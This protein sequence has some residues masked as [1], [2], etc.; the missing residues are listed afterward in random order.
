MTDLLLIGLGS[1]GLRHFVASRKLGYKVVGVDPKHPE[2]LH[3]DLRDIELHTGLAGLRGRSFEY[4][5]IANWGPDHISTLREVHELNLSSKF[6]VEKPLSGS[7][8]DLRE[9]QILTM[10]GDVEFT[11]SFP[12][13]YSDFQHSVEEATNGSPTSIS[14]WGGA[15]CI[16]TNGSHWLDLAIG[17]FGFPV[18]VMAN[19]DSQP[20]NP[21]SAE[22]DFVEGT[23]SYQFSGGRK[24]DLSFDNKSW[25]SSTA[26]FLFSNGILEIKEGAE[27]YLETVDKELLESTPV[28]RTKSPNR[29]KKF[30]KSISLDEAFQQMHQK[31]SEGHITEDEMQHDLKVAA[32]LLMAFESNSKSRLMSD[33]ELD[34]SMTSSEASW[35]IS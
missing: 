15:Q 34:S 29:A 21:R 26:R 14:V 12:K 27:F 35:K 6:I 24:L 30:H 19:F 2:L 31:I 25:V 4:C 3:E 16:S 33:K 5:V 7:F 13:R 17:L 18:S 32:W 9:L 8:A 11:V 1:V 20:I 28:T 23:A 22:L 10:S